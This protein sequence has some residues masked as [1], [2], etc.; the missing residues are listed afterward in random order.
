MRGSLAGFLAQM[1]EEAEHP[2]GGAERGQSM[3]AII[4]FED[5][6]QII[7]HLKR[8]VALK[9]GDEIL[10]EHADGTVQHMIVIGITEDGDRLNAMFFKQGHGIGTSSVCWSGVRFPE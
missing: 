5:K 7:P 9:Q 10:V 3:A 8:L 1:A 6:E 2:R 4:E